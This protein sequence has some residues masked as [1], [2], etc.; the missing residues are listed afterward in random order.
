MVEVDVTVIVRQ[1]HA[2]SEKLSCS[3]PPYSSGLDTERH[4]LDPARRQVS[5]PLDG[6]IPR[7]ALLNA[8]PDQMNWLELVDEASE[9]YSAQ[10]DASADPDGGWD[11]DG[12]LDDDTFGTSWDD[13][14]L[15][16]LGA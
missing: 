14:A 6:F 16:E 8:Q 10:I 9:F 15:D 12:G 4:K 7:V 13:E 1:R 11:P 3:W 5:P 2:V